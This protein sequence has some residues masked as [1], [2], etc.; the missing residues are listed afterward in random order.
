MLGIGMLGG[1]LFMTNALDGQIYI[2]LFT[3]LLL[4]QKKSWKE[5][6]ENIGFVMVVFTVVT[7]PFVAH[8]KSFVSGVAL[9]CPPSFLANS[10]IGP[11][12]FE[13]IEKCQRS[14]LWMM[15]LLWGIF[16]YLG[17]WYFSKL[18]K[19]KNSFIS[20]LFVYGLGLILFA[21]FFYFKDIYPLH[22]RSNT[23][24][25]LGY[26]AFILSYIA[27][28]WV[29]WRM[30]K[31]KNWTFWIMGIPLFFLAGIFPYFSINS[32]FGQLSVYRG[33]DGTTW[34]QNQ[35]PKDWAAIVW[36]NNHKN[37]GDSIVEADGDSY[38]DYGRV[39]T[40]T[41]MPT[42]IG[43]GV[44]EWLWRGGYEIV[45]PRKEEVRQIYENPTLANTKYILA[46]Y[47]VKY[48]FVG[49]L[50]RTKFLKLDTTGL[51]S[52]GHKVFVDGDTFIFQVN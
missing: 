45:P 22:F 8:F 25:K 10:K 11:V 48:I 40:Y 34:I 14:P 16:V 12:I 15:L 37:P 28:S 21:E 46:K 42:I 2:G 32:Y 6:A 24:F 23:M 47:N 7:I 26:Q 17:V 44:H 1:L 5:F 18:H 9:N 38:T 31:S 39:S 35:Y 30:V 19:N 27:G 33:L 29:T 4:I 49:A 36:L 3:V 51:E 43:W 41:G 50:E 52:L 20:V 13:S